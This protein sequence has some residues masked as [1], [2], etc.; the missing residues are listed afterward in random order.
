MK[1]RLLASVV[2]SALCVGFAAMASAAPM[3]DFNKGEGQ[4]DLGTW[5]SNAGF[6]DYD[7]GYKWNL[8]GGVE[9]A[10]A[11]KLGLQY[12][13]HGLN[14]KND[15]YT[16]EGGGDLS[17]RQHEVNLLY[18]LCKG[19]AV[20]AGWS[21]IGVEE[22][23]NNIAQLGLVGKAPLGKNFAVYGLASIG[24]KSTFTGEAGLAYTFAKDFDLNV[25]YRYLKTDLEDQGGKF[26]GLLLGLTYRFGGH[27]AE[28]APAA[29]AEPTPAPAVVEPAA[30]L[31]DYYLESIHF[32]FDDDVVRSSEVSKVDHFVQVAKENPTHVF[33]LVG[34]T[35]SKGTDTYN[36]DLS[37]RRVVNVKKMAENKG[38]ATDKMVAT[39][40]GE[41]DPASTNATDQGRADNRRV[42]I[43]EHK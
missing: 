5:H 15:R 43:Y 24:T 22:A 35:D 20:S 38:V 16:D 3:T 31:K 8:T 21:R 7:F 9:Y 11:N 18:N 30:E 41:N 13:Y 26:K 29:V 17:G 6:D 27:K 1:K 28:A 4:I 12:A 34:N 33:K 2:V 32:D 42:D 14:A 23:A 10:L 25:G 37:E 40:R 36:K 19:V 39:Y